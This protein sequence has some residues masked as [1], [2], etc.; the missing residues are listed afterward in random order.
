MPVYTQAIPVFPNPAVRFL[1]IHIPRTAGRFFEK[2]ILLNGLHLEDSSKSPIDEDGNSVELR[3][4]AHGQYEKYYSVS[5]IPHITIVRNP[6][7]RFISCSIFL[8]RMYGD[9]IQEAMEDPIMFG[10]MLQNFP[11]PQAF[12]WFRPQM[13]F[14][15]SETQIWKLEDGFGEDF[16]EFVSGVLGMEFKI[17]DVPY[18]KLDTD[19]TKRL[20]KRDK[21]I[22]NIRAIYRRD[23]EQLYPELAASF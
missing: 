23:Y 16:E 2:N 18:D 10:T 4:L 17:K 11:L 3:H 9:D 7:D 21:L 20:E 8:K 19:E 15:T 14:I 13:D 6:V 22:D 12:N 1:F 5:G